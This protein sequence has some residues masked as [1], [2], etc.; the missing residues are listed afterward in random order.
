MARPMMMTP[1]VRKAIINAIRAG[2][3]ESAAA[4]HAGVSVKTHEAWML[5]GKSEIA[6]LEGCSR[7]SLKESEKPYVEYYT[8]VKKAQG[9]SEVNLVALVTRHATEDW[10][11]AMKLL[12]RRFPERW[13]ETRKLQHTGADGAPIAIELIDYDTLP[14]PEGPESGEPTE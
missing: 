7:C 9:D 5:R 10:R 11:A 12:A 13:A 4:N 14:E 6:R 1:D 3:Y 2:S 8:A